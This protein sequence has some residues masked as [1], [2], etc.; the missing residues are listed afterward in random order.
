MISCLNACD[1]DFGSIERVTRM[2]LRNLQDC[3]SGS[4]ARIAR[5]NLRQYNSCQMCVIQVFIEGHEF[6][7]SLR[8]Y[9]YKLAWQLL[10]YWYTLCARPFITII[11]SNTLVRQAVA[12]PAIEDQQNFPRCG[13]NYLENSL[14]SAIRDQRRTFSSGLD[15]LLSTRV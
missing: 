4:R 14:V 8:R 6:Q 15:N 12:F 3:R 5:Q 10:W 9:V 1:C 2:T 13:A 11:P 7:I